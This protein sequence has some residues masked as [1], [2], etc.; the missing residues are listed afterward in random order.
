M[1]ATGTCAIRASAQTKR[2]DSHRLLP[3]GPG[4]VLGSYGIVSLLGA[5]GMGEVYRAR[6]QR[7]GRDVAL[8]LLPQ[9]V[10]D[11]PERVA[12]FQREAQLLASLNHA[13]IGAIYGLEQLPAARFL[14]LELAEGGTLAARIAR[15]P[16]PL[17]EASGIARQIALALQAAHDKG[18]VHRDLKPSNVAFTAAGDVK[19]LDF[20]LA[21]LG[22]R[23]DVPATSASLSPTITSPALM[24]GVGALL[25][26]AAYMAPEQAK[27][28]PADKRSDVWAFGCVLYE[29]LTGTRAFEGDDI[30]D[31]LANV[32]KVEPDWSR[33]P[34]SLPS[35]IGVLLRRCLAKDA[36][37]RC[38]DMAAALILLEESTH[39]SSVASSPV[40]SQQRPG[41][42]RRVAVPAAVAAVIGASAIAGTWWALRPDTPRVVRTAILVP[43]RA[44]A[45]TDVTITP[46]GT[47]IAYV[48]NSQS[49]LLVRALDGLEPTPLAA[50][51]SIRGVFSSPDGR[52]VGYLDGG[53]QLMRVALSGGPPIGIA[54]LDAPLRGATWMADDTII[55]G[56]AAGATGLQRIAAAG[57]DLTILTRPDPKQG[58]GDHVLPSRLPDDGAVLFT[59][60]SNS[61]GLP[62]VAVLDIPTGAWKVLVRGAS[63]ARYVDSGHLLY[64]ADGILQ[65]VPFD[66]KS[67]AIRGRA[68][69]VLQQFAVI[70]N[71]NA[72]LD[73]ATNGTLVYVPASATSR[74][75]V[76]VDRNGNEVTIKAPGDHQ[77]MVPR[78]SPDGRR[79]AFHDSAGGE[80]DVW[81]QDLER[82]T[83]ERLTTDPGRDSEPVWS[84]DSTRIAYL[85]TGQPGGAGIFV[86]RADGTGSPERLTTGTHLP[87]YWSSDG[88]WLAYA[89]FGDRGISVATVSALMAVDIDGDHTPRALLKGS[90]GRI[91]PTERWIA[92]TSTANGTNEVYVLPFPDLS[93]GRW[94]ISTDGG[95]NPTWAPDGK[96]LFY[97]RGLAMM[98]VAVT[99]ED[100]AKWPRPTMLFDGQYL[101]DT[102]PTH[103]DAAR[104]GRLLMVKTGSPGGD[105]APRQ[106]I[107]VQNWF[108]ELRRLVP[109]K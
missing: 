28:K 2:A 106:F 71:L 87:S 69:P 65:A 43:G 68:V 100:P 19:V 91:S 101:F 92:I 26:T 95:L 67:R 49:Q 14:V 11:D 61:G 44:G 3:V 45:T 99:G 102:G 86:R 58:D 105:D 73:V 59:I 60:T 83:A 66:L 88:K 22:D 1:T 98:A 109:L 93:G 41:L 97:R 96:T 77:Y 53:N 107:V 55:F 70:G 16:I 85:S 78:L 7:L 23:A 33:L 94:R 10:A 35:A 42:V 30:A 25:G 32:L 37:Q 56:T 104:D 47:R 9:A 21:K 52:S 81:V 24:T 54:S 72:V 82:G 13:H 15:G 108:E 39:L 6:D 51:N 18:V 8:K 5:G 38:G 36:R 4:T 103:F 75:P 29:M 40:T 89:D 90:A 76:W 74:V 80:Y 31:T 34:P 57:G 79:L 46:D 63:H 64:S 12:R 84:H 62:Q 27:G 17:D 48:D 20:G 50:G